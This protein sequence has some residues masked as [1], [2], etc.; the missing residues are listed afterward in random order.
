MPQCQAKPPCS[1]LSDGSWQRHHW[2]LVRPL[3][4]PYVCTQARGL[5]HSRDAQGFPAFCVKERSTV[6]SSQSPV[7][8][9]AR[10]PQTLTPPA[11]CVKERSTVWSSQSP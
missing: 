2:R 7:F 1:R 4:A 9:S 5:V 10:G 11:F 8:V 3:R 6:W